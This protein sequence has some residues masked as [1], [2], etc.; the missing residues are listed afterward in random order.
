MQN[1]RVIKTL[2]TEDEN[3]NRKRLFEKALFHAKEGKVLYIL[4]EELNE[5]P[6]LSQDLN[7]VDRYYIKMISFMYT[8]NKMS[9]IESLAS[10]A[11]W[12]NV[13]RTII[14]D[15]LNKFANRTNMQNVCGIVAL[16]LDSALSCS[17]AIKSPCHLYIAVTK[18]EVD[19][20]YC[21]LL[22]ELYI[23]S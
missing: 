20:E 5:L 13:P 1:G 3:K 15:S 4:Q 12:H 22:K 21:N 18:D 16:L 2:F 14:I 6:E 23:F 9:L 17:V 8:S 7:T 10:L 19:D 11:Q